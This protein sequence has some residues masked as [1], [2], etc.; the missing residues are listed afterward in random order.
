MCM[1]VGLSHR[2]NGLLSALALSRNFNARSRIS[3]STVSIRFGHS[4]PASSIFC[5]PTLPQR[6]STVVSSTLVAYEWSMLR[7]PTCAQL[8]RVVWMTGVFHCIQVI[9]ISEEFIEPVN[10]R[11]KLVFVAKVVLAELTGGVAHSL[12]CSGDRHRLSRQTDGCA[13]LTNRCHPG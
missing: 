2:K 3:S 10:R 1:R 9:E 13:G 11:Q 7:G 12:E 6:G 5:F 8:L 4:S